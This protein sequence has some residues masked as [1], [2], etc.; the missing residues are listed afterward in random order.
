MS[1]VIDHHRSSHNRINT[2]IILLINI[3]FSVLDYF[4][5]VAA[6][7]SYKRAKK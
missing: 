2:Q 5:P 4:S 6:S 7:P 3:Y 1:D